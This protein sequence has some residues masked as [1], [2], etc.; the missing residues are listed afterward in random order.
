MIIHSSCTKF[1]GH[2]DR[3]KSRCSQTVMEMYKGCVFEQYMRQHVNTGFKAH[4][5]NRGSEFSEK[6]NLVKYLHLIKT[7]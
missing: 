1:A 6:N 2:F 4:M 3:F 7:I 5:N